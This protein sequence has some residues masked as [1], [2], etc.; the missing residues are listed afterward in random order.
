MNKLHNLLASIADRPYQNIRKLRGCY[1]FP[2]FEFS[3]IKMQG[4][5]GANP[6][7]IA[8]I[9][10][11]LQD[12]K[13]PEQ[14]FLTNECKL[15]VAD[16]LIRRFR[17]SIDRFAQQN[18]GKDGSGSF[19]TIALSQ[20]MLNRDSVL[21]GNDTV[22]LRFI[23]SLPAKDQNGVFDAEQ[24]WIMFS[25]E[26]TA[27]VDATFFYPHYD[28]QTRTLL[29]QFI[30]VLKTRSQI[31][32][33][34]RQHDLVAFIANEAKLP[35]HSGVDDRPSIGE[36]VKT[37]QSPASLQITI[38]LSDDRSITGMGINEGITCITGGGYHGKSTLMQAILAGVYAHIPGDGRE[39]AVTREDAFFIRAEEGRSIR[40]V[41]ISPFIGDLPNGLKTDCFSSNNASGS[42]SQAANIVEAIESGSRLLLLDEDT[43]ATNFLVR[44]E[45]IKQILDAAQEPIKPLYS[46][47][48]SLWKKHHVSIIFVVGGLGYFLQKAD[49]CLLMDNYCCEDITAKVRD[50]LGTIAEEDTQAPDFSVS[51]YLAADNFDPAYI[52]HRLN[53]TI[54]KRIKD[55]RNAPRQLEYGMDLVNLDAVAQIA[56]APQLLAIGY[57]LLAL[58]TKLKQPDNQPETIRFWIDWLENEINKHGLAF[59]EPDYPGTLSMPRKYELAAAINRIR[60]LRLFSE[61][62][63]RVSSESG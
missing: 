46:T 62:C 50:R 21:F 13:I 10:I 19:S 59:L 61:R 29:R 27:I 57:C 52:N 2:R 51:R 32:Q 34:M 11:A 44:D 8:A 1:Y 30:E 6:A 42:T 54:P 5:P 16:F 18:R 22:Y 43:C 39:Y 26:L 9:K 24:A 12:C 31:I 17:H 60:S 15:A 28:E 47:V 14:F 20:K 41:D 25:Q 36:S 58:R 48:R 38:P 56:E 3:F 35:R 23:I 53:K 37:F 45:L 7:S 49:T 63:S 4:S 55:L 40:E 33:F